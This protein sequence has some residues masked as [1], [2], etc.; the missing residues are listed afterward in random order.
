[1]GRFVL[2]RKK[3]PEYARP[4]PVCAFL[5]ADRCRG[6]YPD[7]VAP[8]AGAVDAAVLFL[9]PGRSGPGE[10][11]GGVVRR[12]VCCRGARIVGKKGIWIF[13]ICK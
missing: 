8:V 5:R 9:Q 13:K 3:S 11:K 4:G 6:V 12:G 1:M 2:E 10:A 7:P